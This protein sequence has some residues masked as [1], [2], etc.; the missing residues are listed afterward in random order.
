MI[1]TSANQAIGYLG[2][3][4][5]VIGKSL[6]FAEIKIKYSHFNAI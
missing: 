3:R 5:D 1:V 2:K 4:N 6:K